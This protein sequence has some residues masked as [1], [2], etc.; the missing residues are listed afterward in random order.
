MPITMPRNSSGRWIKSAGLALVAMLPFLLVACGGNEPGSATDPIVVAA[1]ATANEPAPVLSASDR[2]LLYS[3]A[4]DSTSATAYI[5]DPNTGQPATVSLTPRR[6]DGQVQ[7]TEPQRDDLIAANVSQVQDALDHEAATVPFDL[8]SDIAAAVRVVQGPATLL[9]LSSGLSTAGGLDLRSAG[10]GANPQAIAAQLKSRGL[11]PDL[12]GWRVIFS[13]LGDTAGRQ[14]ALPL[15]EQATLAS[16]WMAICRAAGA[17]ACADDDVTRPEPPPTSTTLVPAVPVPP[18]TSV[19]GPHGWSGKNVP[20]DQ[21]FAF[22]SARLLPGA[23]SILGPL[24]AQARSRDLLVS[25]TGYA[26][27]DGGSDAY[28]RALSQVRAEAVQTRLI[29]LGVNADQIV[30]VR[31]L[32]TDGKP[33]SACY[34]DGRLNEA[35]C[36]RLRRVVILLSPN[37]AANS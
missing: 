9:V 12:A 11:L 18:V 34:T 22:N 29:A 35:I 6:P 13:G 24:A 28:N 19:T 27:P 32:G 30:Q 17:V 26:S 14:P 33:R 3:A 15:P 7:Y 31:G 5:V 37:S 10:W 1:S 20:A 8:L 2:D 21:F 25:I 36:A 23:D 4:A 16:Y